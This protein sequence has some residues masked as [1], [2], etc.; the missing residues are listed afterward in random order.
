MYYFSDYF[1]SE[2]SELP[3]ES[4]TENLTDYFAMTEMLLDAVIACKNERVGEG[5]WHTRGSVLLQEETASYLRKPPAVRGFDLEEDLIREEVG[6]AWKFITDRE[7]RSEHPEFLTVRRLRD[8]FSLSLRETFVLLLCAAPRHDLKF[9]SYYRL[10]LDEPKIGGATVGLVDSLLH[11][12]MSYYEAQTEA[13]LLPKGKLAAFFITFAAPKWETGNPL[14]TELIINDAVYRYLIGQ[15]VPAKIREENK[16]ERTEVFSDALT[17]LSNAKGEGFCYIEAG[18]PEDAEYLLTR[19]AKQKGCP[20][21]TIH[22][23]KAVFG[24]KRCQAILFSVIANN[25]FLLVRGSLKAEDEKRTDPVR[26]EEFSVFLQKIY[27]ALRQIKEMRIWLAG[28][29]RMPQLF[30]PPQLSASIFSLPLPDVSERER[31]WEEG[32]KEEGVRIGE[33]LDLYDLADCHELS[34]TAIRRVIFQAAATMRLLQKEVL[35]RNLLQEILFKQSVSD[36]DHLATEVKA[37]YTWEDI[38]LESSQK[39]RLQ[40]ACDRYRLRNRIGKD[41]GISKKNAYGNAVI[42]LMYGPPGT[43]KTMAAQ[44]I[45]N[46]VMTPLYRVDVSQIFSKYIGET[47]KN[48]S[49][50]FDEAQKRSVVLFFDEADALFTKRTEIKDS[51]DK[52]ANSDTSFLLQKVEEYNGISI[53]ATNNYQSF[54]PAFMRR[55]SYVVR[56]ERPDE[57]VR[58]RMWEHMLPKE[59]P[60]DSDVD[61]AWLAAQFTDLSGSNIKSILLTATYFAAAGKRSVGMRDIIRATRYEFEKLGRL[62]D[63]DDFGRFAIYM[64]E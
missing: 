4:V 5:D 42:L 54:D 52:Y 40:A 11:F 19:L 14:F 41:W 61:F 53:L 26:R 28:E 64:Q 25:G 7:N 12:F 45:A 6:K 44:A 62:I 24:S 32:F 55:L 48:L 17:L 2:K 31:I 63:S 10:F 20:L 58:K 1:N 22:A 33:D 59:V 16:P 51:H 49:R 18:D 29:A 9:L 8:R 50:I 13:L 46:E 60:L 37:Q 56:F 34:Y 21:Y 43:G 39:E 36:F 23:D 27:A 3:Y 57:E 47:Q 15:D 35:D 38:Y 30:L